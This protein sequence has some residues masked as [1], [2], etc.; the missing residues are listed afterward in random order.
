MRNK[1]RLVE[2]EKRI[3][4]IKREDVSPV[5]LIDGPDDVD[6]ALA[7]HRKKMEAAGIRH[8]NVIILPRG[9]SKTKGKR[10]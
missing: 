7:E 6:R 10:S 8:M 4:P 3:N 5:I 9:S 1:S 2:I